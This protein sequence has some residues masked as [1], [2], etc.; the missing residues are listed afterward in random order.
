MQDGELAATVSSNQVVNIFNVSYQITPW[1]ESTFRYSVFNPYDSS[2]SRDELRG[3]IRD[4]S[5]GVKARLVEES[6]LMPQ[7]AL[8]IRDILGTGVWNSEYLVATKQWGA[9]DTTLGIGWGRLADRG[10]FE[11]PLRIL[12]DRFGF[13]PAG[14]TVGGP[15]GTGEVRAKSFFR[16]DVGLFGG[17][18]YQLQEAPFSFII[19]YSSDSYKRE[20]NL[21]SLKSNSPFNA[22]V[23]WEPIKGISLTASFQQG[24]FFGITLKTVGDFKS[25]KPRRQV[26]FQSILSKE[27]AAG[28]PE[29][30]DLTEWYDR[31]LFDVERAGLRVYSAHGRPGDSEISFLLANDT[32]AETG[33]AVRQF[34]ATAEV[35][36]P[37]EIKRMNV[38]LVETELK[39]PS[40]RYQRS[41][42]MLRRANLSREEIAKSLIKVEPN[43]GL[44]R[45]LHKTDFGFP[46]L[47]IGADLGL[48]LQL[49]DPNEPLKH[50]LFLKG[51]AR[52]ALSRHLNV[53]SAVSI[54]LNNDFN[55]SRPSDSV[56]PRVRSEL[57]QYLTQ[58]KT[59]V[60]S[61]FL[62][63][64]RSLQSDLHLRSYVGLVEEMF[65]GVGSEFLYEPFGK[66]WALGGNV[67]WVKQRA[68]PKDFRFRDYSVTTGHV[69]AFYA[70]PFYN[71]DF[72]LHVG[73]Y[74]AGDKGY[75]VEARRTFDNG[76]AIGAFFT[77]TNVSSEDFG[78]GSF[79]KGLF[80]RI[81]VHLL[82]PINT[83]S[84]Y[85]TVIRSIERD[86]GRR[87]EGNIGNLW[88]DRRPVRLDALTGQVEKMLP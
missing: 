15:Q 54:D 46:K 71:L 80:L 17:V 6:N 64:R 86:G 69:S 63:D 39:S 67:N 82:L 18:E 25:S 59:G 75:S 16:G 11:N 42:E 30:L 81:P 49:M 7:L 33:D 22:G 26:E 9:L 32:Y 38:Q 76:F 21:G 60:D 65:G 44:D 35:H 77:R 5:Y 8:G 4:R 40:I 23:R 28:A 43:V 20:A 85:T 61:F 14:A 1:L 55:T 74:L 79:D 41:S 29:F 13:R 31:L 78:E 58:G 3:D 52:L 70:S 12:D 57:N 2:G 87:L 36:V 72:G 66:R 27:G 62:E 50:Q 83:R 24:D 84:H 73:Q 51:T 45:P 37:P 53:W 56:L 19:E 47:A 34:L 10:A 48:R 68:Y 88:W